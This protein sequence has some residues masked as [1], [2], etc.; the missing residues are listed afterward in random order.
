MKSWIDLAVILAL[1]YVPVKAD[2]QLISPKE[3]DTV[4]QLWPEVK[5]FLD[6]PREVREHHAENL[7]KRARYGFRQFSGA[8]P[9][10]FRWMGDKNGVYALKQ[11]RHMAASLHRLAG[12]VRQ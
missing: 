3:G 8:K 2:I 6:A 5:A 12:P 10:E 11:R 1:G 7:S 4:E 9:V